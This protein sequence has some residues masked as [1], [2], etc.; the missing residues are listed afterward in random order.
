MSGR[1]I[2]RRR[3][4]P[5]NEPVDARD[6]AVEEM[7]T[8]HTFSNEQLQRFRDDLARYGL[9]ALPWLSDAYN[10]AFTTTELEDGQ[11][12]LTATFVFARPKDVN[13]GDT[14]GLLVVPADATGEDI[15]LFTRPRA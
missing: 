10:M 9:E 12:E 1:G 6:R 4:P 3:R 15:V 8:W 11:G 14:L 5:C 7:L 2:P 13:V